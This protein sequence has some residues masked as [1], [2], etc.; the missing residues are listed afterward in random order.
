MRKIAKY[1]NKI[2]KKFKKSQKVA[3]KSVQISL[4]VR[5]NDSTYNGKQLQT[6][7]VRRRR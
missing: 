5:D 6:Q 3:L 1:D 7:I 2:G 4:L